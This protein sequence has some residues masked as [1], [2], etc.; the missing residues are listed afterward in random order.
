[1]AKTKAQKQAYNQ[2]LSD[3]YDQIAGALGKQSAT[4]TQTTTQQSNTYTPTLSKDEVG[5]M[6]DDYMASLNSQ[7]NT[8]SIPKLE[9]MG[10]NNSAP[11]TS[12]SLPNLSDLRSQLADTTTNRTEGETKALQDYIQG[13]ETLQQ[14]TYKQN[15]N[16]EINKVR[17]RL[18]TDVNLTDGERKANEEYLSGLQTLQAEI[19]RY[20]RPKYTSN[21]ASNNTTNNAKQ[22]KSKYEGKNIHIAESEKDKQL[23]ENDIVEINGQYYTKQ[24][25]AD[26]RQ[27]NRERVREN[28]L[29]KSES[30]SVKGFIK[31]FESANAQLL[32]NQV[33]AAYQMGQEELKKQEI[34]NQREARNQS[35]R[36]TIKPTGNDTT[37]NPFGFNKD[38]SDIENT[39]QRFS[40]PEIPE[41]EIKLPTDAK[42]WM[43]TRYA[44]S[45][46]AGDIRNKYDKATQKAFEDGNNDALMQVFA[47]LDDHSKQVIQQ[48][49]DEQKASKDG[50]AFNRDIYLNKLMEDN[51]GMTEETATKF[52]DNAKTFVDDSDVVDKYFRENVDKWLDPNYTIS[53][54]EEY[55]FKKYTEEILP[56]KYPGFEDDWDDHYTRRR[57]DNLSLLLGKSTKLKADTSNGNLEYFNK[58][59]D[60]FDKLDNN[61]A[62]IQGVQ[63]AMPFGRQLEGLALNLEGMS[64]EQKQ[65]WYNNPSHQSATQ[66]P[67]ASM[68]GQVATTLGKYIA[69]NELMQSIPA[70]A[71]IGDKVGG[72]VKG[73]SALANG[74]RNHLSNVT[75][76]TMLDIAVDT[77]PNLINDIYDGKNAG[78]VLTNAIENVGINIGFNLFAEALL[79]KG[80][81]TNNS[82]VRETLDDM[83][84]ARIDKVVFNNPKVEKATEKAMLDLGIV[85]KEGQTIQEVINTLPEEQI[86]KLADET[87][88]IIKSEADNVIKA[89]AN[90]NVTMSQRLDNIVDNA[91]TT[92]NNVVDDLAKQEEEIRQLSEQVG[93]TAN[94]I[95]N[96]GDI[97]LTGNKEIDDVLSTMGEQNVKNSKAYRDIAIPNKELDDNINTII[98]MYGKDLPQDEVIALKKCLSR[99]AETGNEAYLEQARRMAESLDGVYNGRIYTNKKGGQTPFDRNP[100]GT[101]S[102]NVD[103][104][105]NSLRNIALSKQTT[106]DGLEDIS[107]QLD[108]M[109]AKYGATDE[110]LDATNRVKQAFSELIEYPTRTNFDTFSKEMSN[111]Y[112]TFDGKVAFNRSYKGSVSGQSFS[113]DEIDNIVREAEDMVRNPL[114]ADN[115]RNAKGD[116]VQQNPKDYNYSQMNTNTA[117]KNGWVDMSKT[118]DRLNAIY[119]VKHDEKLFEKTKTILDDNPNLTNDIIEGKALINSDEMVVASKIEC[120]KLNEQI[121]ALEELGE[122]A[123]KAQLNNLMAQKTYLLKRM[124][125]SATETGRELRAWGLLNNTPDGAIV[126]TQRFMDNISATQVR[127]NGGKIN[128]SINKTAEAL[129][130]NP[131]ISANDVKNLLD[132]NI[133]KDF[134]DEDYQFIANLVGN[135]AT[136]KEVKDLLNFR[137]ANGLWDIPDEVVRKVNEGYKELENLVEGSKPYIEKQTE[138]MWDLANA[139]K[140]GTSIADKFDAWRYLAM[141]GNPK[142]H[143]RNIVGN[144]MFQMVTSMSNTLAATIEEGL[145]KMGLNF[146]RTK[147]IL[148]PVN[149]LDLISASWKDAVNSRAY[150]DLMTNK[151]NENIGRTIKQQREVFDSK[152]FRGYNKI[153]SNWLTGEDFGAMRFKYQTSLAGYLKANGYDKTI[154][155][156]ENE[157]KAL[158]DLSKTRVLTPE[159]I[160][161]QKELTQQVADL[162]KAR[163]YAIN[164]AK[165]SAFHADSKFADDLVKAF[166]GNG[167]GSKAMNIIKEG[168]L[169]FKKTPINILKAGAEYSPLNAFKNVFYD[170]GQLTKGNISPSKFIENISKTFT[171]SGITLLGAYLY[172]QGILNINDGADQWQKDLEGI[173]NYSIKLGNKTLTID[174]LAPSAMP[175]FMGVEIG[176]L[177]DEYF[178]AKYFD[179]DGNLIEKPEEVGKTF[180]QFF[181][182]VYS[183]AGNLFSP[184]VETSMLNG[185]TDTISAIGD[186]ETNAERALNLVGTPIASYFSQAIPTIGGQVART[187]DPVR[188]STYTGTTNGI[189]KS[190]QK[191]MNKI[192]FLSMLNEPYVDARGNTQNNSPFDNPVG[193]AAYQFVSPFYIS[194]VNQ[195]EVDKVLDDIYEKT[196]SEDVFINSKAIP[197]FEDGTPLTPEQNTEYTTYRGQ[198]VYSRLAE[199]FET[200]AFKNANYTEKLSMVKSLENK[201][202]KDAINRL[203]DPNLEVGDYVTDIAS[204][205]ENK[206]LKNDMKEQGYPVNDFFIEAYQNNDTNVLDKA[207]TYQEQASKYTYTNKKGEEKTLEITKDLYEDLEK[208]APFQHERYLEFV[209]DSKTNG[210]TANKKNFEHFLKGDLDNYLEY[211]KILDDNNADD[212]DY[213]YNMWEN[214][215]NQ[216]V[217]DYFATRKQLGQYGVGYKEAVDVWSNARQV[218]PTLTMPEFA[219]TYN[220]IDSNNKNGISQ[221]EM[222]NYL[223][224]NNIPKVEGM[225]LYK[226]YAPD[227]K[228]A[229]VDNPKKKTQKRW[230]QGTSK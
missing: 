104:Y 127:K 116:L 96:T 26:Q 62:I 14:N 119:E 107:K 226:A 146:E 89:E 74:L 213:Y 56:N 135:G 91:R 61:E 110:M 3:A 52:L 49:Y 77:T 69:G 121:K 210:Y 196:G 162:N 166:S 65:A 79:S 51:P 50:K 108:D 221:T 9:D 173:Q 13:I 172:N 207:K 83:D 28:K 11:S 200:D 75:N 17:N 53:P 47:N 141:L 111:L 143:A 202:D 19:D 159:Q 171:G 70:L 175:L 206:A 20:N 38:F 42:K 178:N 16:D 170:I 126:N 214:K 43:D 212:S 209:A 228:I 160:A 32:N 82:I 55:M 201:I 102:F 188:R 67:Y 101:F 57:T 208:I 181:S 5:K 60:V 129:T 194:D 98:N 113:Y 48:D 150:A 182:D 220:L 44:T 114:K 105:G 219:K 157:L 58:L 225:E 34:R 223:N 25:L 180:G 179:E 148:N 124:R 90:N 81:Y 153:N 168:V 78:E 80:G 37:S 23:N 224:N 140:A 117:Q 152:F 76:A 139:T 18:D 154:F 41:P 97:A 164:Q 131:N 191:T 167:A 115:I 184:I 86:V 177:W 211:K 216:G 72:I 165:Y 46:Q 63:N 45:F 187:I 59:A 30:D 122:Q 186:G 10:Q 158:N 199:L 130:S 161:K 27:A 2:M 85:K 136:T 144:T 147:A 33:K 217:K 174:S 100:R 6:Y 112:D 84:N 193:S 35:F 1:M 29:M 222:I 22:K 68:Y 4:P 227:S 54:Y 229:Y 118:E 31:K 106:I 138:I 156:A 204:D 40:R 8:P 230:K 103:N 88:A 149:D 94:N 163:D 109:V 120:D 183:T 7:N 134:G 123:D 73:E 197:K 176:K 12:V 92:T 71:G 169:P 93:K 218:I 125:E 99:Y 189:D 128:N 145:A 87:D 185:L 190:I 155:D 195:T 15:Y 21:N 198:E 66:N 137:R 142:T 95:A 64:D 132:G 24:A 36:E 133:F 215:G 39:T 151:Y 192:P 205:Y 203:I